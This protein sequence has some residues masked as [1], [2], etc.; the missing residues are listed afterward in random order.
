[1]A[2]RALFEGLVFDENDMPVDVVY[3]GEEP[4]YVV[5]DAGFRRHIP[6]EQVDRQILDT[7]R[8][9]VEGHEE[10]IS[11][12]T[13]KMLGQEDIFS[14]AMIENQLKNIDQQLDSLFEIGI[15]EE[16]RA[17]MGMMGFKITINVH[18]EVVDVEQPGG[19]IDPGDED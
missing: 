4:C 3:I 2:S 17:Y 1:M 18:G 5:D 16:G 10:I 9:M 12:Q 19:I 11:E 7:M 8:E 15:P 6:T 14:R 13:A